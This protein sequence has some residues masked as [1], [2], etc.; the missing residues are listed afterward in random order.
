MRK[1]SK[2]HRSH[3]SGKRWI[4]YKGSRKIFLNRKEKQ[5]KKC[6]QEIVRKDA[7]NI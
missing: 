5:L 3:N 4:G 2:K 7:Q 1:K 6:Q